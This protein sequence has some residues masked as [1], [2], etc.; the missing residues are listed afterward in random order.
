[1][2]PSKDENGTK[3]GRRYASGQRAITEFLRP[4]EGSRVARTKENF[5]IVHPPRTKRI[6]VA[7]SPIGRFVRAGSQMF[8]KRRQFA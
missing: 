6:P 2:S 3:I 1:M 7:E 8:S 4:N 5:T